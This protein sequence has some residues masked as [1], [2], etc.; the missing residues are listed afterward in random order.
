VY[1]VLAQACHEAGRFDEGQRAWR[2]G[3][4]RDPGGRCWGPEPQWIATVRGE[5]ADDE[6]FGGDWWVVGAYLEGRLPRYQR[7]RGDG[8]AQRLR[9]FRQEACG[10]VCGEQDAAVRFFGGL[11]LSEHGVLLTHNDL[12]AVRHT[13]RRLHGEAFAMHMEILAEQGP[14]SESR[15]AEWMPW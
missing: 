6:N 9:R 2:E 7:T 5:F 3:Y 11:F 8:L 14:P 4:G 1:R 13:M 12:A 10:A 15:G